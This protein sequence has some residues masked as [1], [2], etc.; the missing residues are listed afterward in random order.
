MGD[1]TEF[2]IVAGRNCGEAEVRISFQRAESLSDVSGKKI[3]V[4]CVEAFPLFNSIE[5]AGAEARSEK[6]EW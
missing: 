1:E 6:M 4:R 2:R 5:G 3:F